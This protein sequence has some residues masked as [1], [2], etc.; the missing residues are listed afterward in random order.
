MTILREER[1][2]LTI[3][4]Q[5]TIDGIIVNDYGNAG[6]GGCALNLGNA[7][8]A[9]VNNFKAYSYKNWTDGID[10]FAATNITIN[11]YYGRTGDDSIA[12]YTA[13]ANGGNIWYGNTKNITV[14][15]SILKP[16]FARPINIGTHGF[17]HGR[18]AAGIRLEDV[19][20]LQS[21]PLVG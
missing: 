7:T 3:P 16:D 18:L 4:N 13:R 20:F 6:W 10:T 11:D 19:S 2:R 15:N 5:A 9:T 17:P 12:I 8:N 21:G 14:T 1:Y